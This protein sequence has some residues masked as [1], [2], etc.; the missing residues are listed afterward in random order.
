MVLCYSNINTNDTYK[1]KYFIAI[2]FL[3][4][5]YM[6]I[7]IFMLAGLPKYPFPPTQ[8]VTLFHIYQVIH[9]PLLLYKFIYHLIQL[10]FGLEKKKKKSFKY[11][12]TC[13]K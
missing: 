7:H 10:S 3:S 5:G 1:I 13:M 4:L 8:K 9:C 6:P 11:E 2:Y 12:A